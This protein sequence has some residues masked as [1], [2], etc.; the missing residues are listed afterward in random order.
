MTDMAI[1]LF[2]AALAFGLSRVLQ[3]PLIPLMLVAGMGLR[4]SGMALEEDAA[5][6]ALEIGLA[7]LVFGAGMELNPKR[8]GAKTRIVIGVGLMQFLIMGAGGFVVSYGLGFDW[9]SSLY[10]GLAI[11]TSSTLVI[12]R[13]LKTRQQMFEPFGRVV[14]GVLL[15][16]DLLI[17]LMI[18]IL[19]Q[20]PN[21]VVAVAHGLV[22][23]SALMALSYTGLRWVM[24]WLV[25]RV[26]L[27][28]ETL[29][30]M[31]IMTLFAFMG[32]AHILGLPVITGAFLAG[33]SLSAFPVNSVA[34]GLMTSLTTFFMAMFFVMLGGLIHWPS[35]TEWWLAGGLT[36]FIILCTPLLVVPVAERLGL[37]ARSAIESGLLL[38]MTSEFSLVVVLQ[39]LIIGQIAPEVFNVVALATVLTMTITPLIATDRMTWRLMRMHPGTAPIYPPGSQPLRDHILMLGYG[40][41]GSVTLKALRAAGHDVIVIEDDPVVVRELQ[42]QGVRTVQGDGSDWRILDMVGAQNARLIISSMRRVSDT[43]A[44]IK[45]LGANGPKVVMRVFEPV[46]ADRVRALGGI[47]VLSSNA[48][49][50]AFLEWYNYMFPAE[51]SAGS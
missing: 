2:M 4:Y 36:L 16:Q 42:E 17:I 13:M 51:G 10:I 35:S 20:I 28:R 1:I 11:T 38:A 6:T 27:D 43:E 12:I 44:V 40:R 50:D 41:G 37:T 46:E 49:A 18:V 25:L 19:I 29:G 22:A 32:L 33:V 34:R 3:L 24:P 14:A 9:I 26:K 45:Y 48:A 23:L 7:V 31:I 47:P 15:F 21:G 5:R 30:L 39:G 8:F